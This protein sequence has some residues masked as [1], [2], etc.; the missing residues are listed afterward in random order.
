MD[1]VL[2]CFG[3][4]F[5]YRDTQQERDVA[6]KVTAKAKNPRA[7]ATTLREVAS[8]VSLEG[9]G[10]AKRCRIGLESWSRSLFYRIVLR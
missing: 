5:R 4:R 1:D 3:C 10:L 7:L 9:N 2:F 6:V 8:A